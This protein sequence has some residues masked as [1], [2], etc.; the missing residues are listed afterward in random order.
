MAIG[1]PANQ[2][3]Q[4]TNDHGETARLFIALWPGAAFA[5]ALHAQCGVCTTG[6]R[7]RVVTPQRVH[8]TLHF[9]GNLPRQQVPALVSALRVP[10]QPFEL[11]FNHCEQ[12]PH[13]LRVA[14]PDTIA[15]QLTQLHE[16]LGEALQ[17][18]ELP[19]DERPFQPHLTLA[20][21]TTAPLP[22]PNG[23]PLRWPVNGYV[24]VESQATPSGAYRVVQA[25]G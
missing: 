9:L 7:A 24:L 23:P 13:G 16:A 19:V 17:G 12:W 14:V 20:R 6:P 22:A 11:S 21:R 1:S 3:E 4:G 10:F 5:S 18:L 25:Y 15:P 8:L 2:T